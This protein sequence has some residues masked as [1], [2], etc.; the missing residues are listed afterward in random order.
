MNHSVHRSSPSHIEARA[1]PAIDHVKRRGVIDRVIPGS[2]RPLK[3]EENLVLRRDLRSRRG[4]PVQTEEPRTRG[5]FMVFSYAKSY[6]ASMGRY[7]LMSDQS[8]TACDAALK[9]QKHDA[10]RHG[11]KAASIR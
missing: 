1:S 10:G 4:I 11:H 6:L 9:R 7:D 5:N 3:F 8:C 2:V